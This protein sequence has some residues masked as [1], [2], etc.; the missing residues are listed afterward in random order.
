MNYSQSDF[1][2]MTLPARATRVGG[3]PVMGLTKGELFTLEAMK[4]MLADGPCNVDGYE[5]LGR[6][7]ALAAMST[8]KSYW[9]LQKFQPAPTEEE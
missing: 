7:A 6:D 4:V 2:R 8:L 1:D 9:D 5:S 3:H